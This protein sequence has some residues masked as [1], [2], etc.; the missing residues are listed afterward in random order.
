MKVTKCKGEGQGSCRRCTDNGKWNIN[1]MCFLYK[2]D[3]MDGCYCGDCVAAI[4]QEQNDYSELK[5]ALEIGIECGL[6]TIG[7]AIFN[8]ELHAMNIFSYDE[9]EDRIAQL[10][11]EAHEVYK[12]GDY[13]PDSKCTDMLM[14]LNGR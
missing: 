3:G 6:A 14:W 13:A 9:M 10:H 2:I 12:L 8:I 4:R 5:S 1:W 11:T 7:E